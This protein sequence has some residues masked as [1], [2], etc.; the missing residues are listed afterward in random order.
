M[1]LQPFLRG[2]VTSLCAWRQIKTSEKPI[3]DENSTSSISMNNSGR[4]EESSAEVEGFL[5]GSIEVDM[6]VQKG[7]R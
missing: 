1:G 6:E 4:H 7:L 5:S 3:G 2:R